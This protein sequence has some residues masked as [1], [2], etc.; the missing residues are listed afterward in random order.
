ERLEGTPRTSRN[1][2]PILHKNLILNDQKIG[3]SPNY[4]SS[5]TSIFHS[6]IIII[7]IDDPIR[8]VLQKPELA[9]RMTV[10]SVELSKFS[11]KYKLR[12]VIKS[13]SSANFI[14]EMVSILEA[15]PRW[16]LHVDGP[17]NSKG[18]GVGIILEGPRQVVLEHSLK[19]DYKT[20]NNQVEYEALLTGL[21][22][23]LEKV[24]NTLQKFDT[25]EVKHIPRADNAC[26]HV[27]KLVTSKAGQHRT[28]FYKTVKSPT[29]E[30]TK[31]LSME[32][33][34]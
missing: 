27:S 5:A 11:L 19:F 33:V 30:E 29:I 2:N 7:R 25:S 31:V 9:S 10:W 1:R 24:V 16:T 32:S 12:G 4:L 28:T 21:D 14:V 26:R 22:M 6:H 8:Q 15:D 23:A 3:P 17:S 20:S 34:D 18:G 13:Q